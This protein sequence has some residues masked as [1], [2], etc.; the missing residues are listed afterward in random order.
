MHGIKNEMFTVTIGSGE[1]YD[2][3]LV[4]DDKRPQYRR[5]IVRGQDGFPS[6][7]SQM[8]ELVN[9][10]AEH[11][12]L[13]DRSPIFDIP[14]EPVNCPNPDTVNYV[15]IC[16]G[17]QGEDRFFPQFYPAHNHDDYKVTNDGTYPGGQLILMQIDAP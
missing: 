7:C 16:A 4:A 9:F 2:L 15:N 3:L 8:V 12:E 13:V 6:L 17:I 1:S 5:Y 11:P 10:A 14:T